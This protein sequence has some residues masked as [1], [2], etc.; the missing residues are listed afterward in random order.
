MATPGNHGSGYAKAADGAPPQW[1]DP[2]KISFEMGYFLNHIAAYVSPVPGFDAKNTI[3]RLDGS[4][5]RSLRHVTVN[6]K[7]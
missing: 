2:G 4:Q 3:L 1:F 6:G 7:V 5:N